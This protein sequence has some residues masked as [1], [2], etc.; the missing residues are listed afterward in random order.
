MREKLDRFF[1][2]SRR[3]STVEAEVRGGMATFLTMGYI[4]FANPAIL[5]SGGV[6]FASAVACTALAAALSCFMM[7]IFGN[8]PIA[9]ASGMGLNSLVA[10]QLAGTMGSWQKAMGLVVIDG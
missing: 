2:I 8:F 10:F 6:P 5:A 1:E 9:L 3:G 7:G 4:L